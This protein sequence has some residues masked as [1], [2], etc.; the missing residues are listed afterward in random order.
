MGFHFHFIFIF[1]YFPPISSKYLN[2]NYIVGEG[3]ERG[4]SR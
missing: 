2:E 4:T 1:I 3:E